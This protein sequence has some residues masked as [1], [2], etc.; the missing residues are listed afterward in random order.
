MLYGVWQSGKYFCIYR[1]STKLGI[2]G[3]GSFPIVSNRQSQQFL[4]FPV[5][6]FHLALPPPFLY[7]L[8]PLP[9]FSWNSQTNHCHILAMKIY[10][11]IDLTSCYKYV[12]NL[13]R[14]SIS[15]KKIDLVKTP[16]Q[17][18]TK[19]SRKL[20]R[21]FGKRETENDEDLTQLSQQSSYDGPSPHSVFP[22]NGFVDLL[23]IFAVQMRHLGN[24]WE[25]VR[26]NANF[27]CKLCVYPLFQPPTQTSQR[28]HG[29]IL[30]FGIMQPIAE[31]YRN[32]DRVEILTNIFQLT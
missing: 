4:T 24:I 3:N 31:I 17:K 9:N 28:S 6:I 8:S 27:G 14:I 10:I 5:E 1:I 29:W 16:G 26:S 20:Q 23:L 30:V 18:S 12:L 11:W 13:T 15:M 7:I 32:M 2:S 19:V 21:W 25:I 22:T